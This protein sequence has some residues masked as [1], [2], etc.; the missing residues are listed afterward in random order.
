MLLALAMLVVM[1]LFLSNSLIQRVLGIDSCLND[2]QGGSKKANI[3]GYHDLHKLYDAAKGFISLWFNYG[4]PIGY[5]LCKCVGNISSRIFWSNKQR[6]TS[7]SDAFRKFKINNFFDLEANYGLIQNVIHWGNNVWFQTSDSIKKTNFGDVSIELSSGQAARVG[8][9]GFISDIY[10]I[11]GKIPEGYGGNIDGGASMLTTEGAWFVDRKARTMNLFTGSV[12]E[13][14]SEG[15]DSFFKQEIRLYLAEDFPNYPGISQG[16]DIG[17]SFGRDY[18]YN[19]V[20]FTK[21][22]YKC[23]K[24]DLLDLDG[25][26]FKL[27]SDQTVVHLTDTEYFENKS[28]TLSYYKH[29][30]KSYFVGFHSY[31]P[32]YYTHDRL[33]LY[34]WEGNKLWKHDND[35]HSYRSI[36]GVTRPFILDVISRQPNAMAK[37]F[38]YN[39]SQL[40][41]RSQ[42]YDKISKSYRRLGAIYDY[43][44]LINSRN[45]SGLRPT[46]L[47]DTETALERPELEVLSRN[48]RHYSF[49]NMRGIIEDKGNI[50]E[51]IETSR[52]YLPEILKILYNFGAESIT[53]K[54]LLEDEYLKYRFVTTNLDTHTQILIKELATYI[55]ITADYNG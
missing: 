25:D 1:W 13:F 6:V 37:D 24:P 31:M 40:W 10:D 30:Q 9:G 7:A 34:S 43:I 12:Q 47:V 16:Y 26:V 48:G 32:L 39:H 4:V 11:F 29:A 18:K 14:N 53:D 42:I 38:V 15:M 8:G 5:N 19:R 49:Y 54:P 44:G 50:S 3:R 33:N 22:D 17:F 52:K 23:L 20:L 36:Y 27:K 2:R 35:N 46:K 55:E 51:V 45:T 21:K 41:L 28:W